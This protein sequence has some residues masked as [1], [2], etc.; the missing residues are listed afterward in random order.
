MILNI[1]NLYKN[2]RENFKEGDKIVMN[3]D[4][5]IS[6]DDFSLKKK[7]IHGTIIKIGPF[8]TLVRLAKYNTCIHNHQMLTDKSIR[9]IY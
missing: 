4:S 1:K 3:A 2:V 9:R 7:R 5:D 8:F 6:E